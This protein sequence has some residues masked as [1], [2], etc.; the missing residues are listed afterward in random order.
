MPQVERGW[1]QESSVLEV[2]SEIPSV[3]SQLEEAKSNEEPTLIDVDE[4]IEE[5]AG[6]QAVESTV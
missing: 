4:K 6:T 2:E 1:L 3:T 5:N